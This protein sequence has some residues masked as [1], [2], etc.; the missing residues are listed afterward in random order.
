MGVVES[1][2]VTVGRMHL[3]HVHET[4]DGQS[5]GFRHVRAVAC[6]S[7]GIIPDVIAEVESLVRGLR[8]SAATGG[9]EDPHRPLSRI[10]VRHV[11]LP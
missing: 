11:I 7:R 5:D 6:H 2:T 10:R 4:V 3:L 1:T 8:C 9:E